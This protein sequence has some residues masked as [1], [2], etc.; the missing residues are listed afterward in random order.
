M[1]KKM[2]GTIACLAASAV[3]GTALLTGCSSTTTAKDTTVKVVDISLTDEEYAFG[4]D[5]NNAE[6]L[7]KANEYIAKVKGDGTF[8]KICENYFGEGTPQA[9]VSASQD[10]GKDQLVVVTNA[11]FS[12]FEYKEG[13]NYYGIDMELV[14]GLADFLDKEL[15]ILDVDFDSVCSYVDTGKADMVAAGLT[16]NETRKQSVT[17][18]DSYYYAS[19]VLLVPQ[20]STKFA[21]CKDA[22]DVLKILNEGKCK[23]GGQSGTTAEFYV[24]GDEEWEFEGISGATWVGYNSG[25]LAANDML[26]GNVDYVLIDKAPAKVIAEKIAKANN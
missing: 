7:T 4:I 19:Q 18:T 20:S 21:N 12:P 22:V 3:L 15:V 24:K 2:T 8:D 26:A 6:L 17:F 9:V 14:S 16:V 11:E 25:S 5:K 13:S 1:K 23:I 10:S